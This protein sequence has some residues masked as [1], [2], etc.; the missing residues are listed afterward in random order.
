MSDTP[1]PATLEN[2]DREPIHIPG[3]IQPHGAL[4]AFDRLGRLT[5]AS[6]NATALLGVPLAFGRPLRLDELGDDA[7]LF[8]QLQQA[9]ADAGG[10][11]IASN[12]CHAVLDGQRFD[13]VVHA[14]HGTVIC[15]FEQRAAHED[16]VA[17]FAH[18]AYRG[19]GALKRQK[20]IDRLLGAAVAAVRELTG[21]DRVMGYRFRHDNSGDI[22]AE[23][24]DNAL[25]PFLGRRYPAT[26]IPAQARR[27]YVLNSLR[28]IADMGYTPVPLLADP[29]QTAPLDLSHSVLR[30]VSPIHVEYLQNMGVAASMS[31]SIVIGGRLWG[32]IAC[33]HMTPRRVPYPIRMAVDVMAQVIAATVQS[34]DAQAREAAIARAAWL[35]TELARVV[36]QGTEVAEAVQIESAALCESLRCDA[37]MVTL[38]GAPRTAR[39][40]APVWALQV[41]D[42]LSTQSGHLVHVFDAAQLPAWAPETPEAERYCGALALR[43]D[44]PRQGW[45]VA[46]R[47]EQIQ[48][49]RWGGKPDKVIA[50]G[51]LGP[52]LTPRGSFEEWRE[53]VRDTAEPWGEVELEIASQLLDSVSRAHAD[54]VLESDQLRSQLWAVLGHDLRN[55]L[56][57]LSM[58]TSAIQSGRGSERLNA[59]VRNSTTRMRQLIASVLDISRLQHGFELTL[60]FEPTDLVP[61]IVQLVDESKVA[62]PTTQILVRLPTTLTA[63]VDPVR[64]AQVI[65]NLLSNARHHGQ[66]EVTLTASSE[67]GHAVLAVG[68]ASPPIPPEVAASLFDPFKRQSTNNQRNPTGM[69]LGLFI[70]YQVVQGHTGSLRHIEGQGT[71]TFEVRVPLRR[72]VS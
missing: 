51:P 70:A 36:G 15:E 37:L 30:S 72:S 26:D 27:L 21:F 19:M 68:N 31:V 16:E 10:D 67:D 65:S 66:G 28:L 69:G 34:L 41:A 64:I 12:S 2:C 52:R 4:L 35:R 14:C 56:Q 6:A 48:T 43:F 44:V 33:H 58:A 62:H 22:V 49:I 60:K 71:V 61:L 5:H 47:R 29:A 7:E 50:H 39:G 53:T 57:S 25:E 20:N 55:P 63:E 46:L 11:E 38:D 59:V 3:S 13:V 24:R 23:A 18:L 54:R 17:R 9:I 1:T 40:V 32:M 45:I 42:W 8:R